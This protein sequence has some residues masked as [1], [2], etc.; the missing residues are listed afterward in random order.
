MQGCPRCGQANAS[1]VICWFPSYT[2]LGVCAVG[3]SLRLPVT[4][5]H[6]GAFQKRSVG[7]SS[8]IGSREMFGSFDV[9]PECHAF[10]QLDVT[11][12]SS[13]CIIASVKS[14]LIG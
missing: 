5:L 3:A 9:R 7:Q 4:T 14:V 1:S 8:S 10:I 2:C 13:G 6:L 12:S 11:V